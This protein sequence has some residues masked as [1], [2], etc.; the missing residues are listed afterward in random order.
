MPAF[1]S[2]TTPARP[3]TRLAAL[4]LAGQSEGALRRAASARQA[5]MVR[6]PGGFHIVRT[7]S[8]AVNWTR[9]ILEWNRRHDLT[10]PR[11]SR[12]AR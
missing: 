7:P 5:E 4:A 1:R 12:A 3:L 8:Q 11:R 6:Y 10:R 9:R 2:L